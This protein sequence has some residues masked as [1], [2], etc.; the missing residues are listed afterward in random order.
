MRSYSENN[1]LKQPEKEK[2]ENFDLVGL[3]GGSSNNTTIDSTTDNKLTIFEQLH[4]NIRE[5]LSGHTWEIVN[6]EPLKFIIA[7]TEWNQIIHGSVINRT[8]IIYDDRGNNTGNYEQTPYLKLHNIIIGAI[9]TKIISHEDPLRPTERKFTI[10]FSTHTG[11][12][13]TA[14]PKPLEEII[15][16]LR[17][18]ALVYMSRGA[19]EAL[20]VIVSAFA[21]DKKMVINT[22]VETPG[23]YLINSDDVSINSRIVACKTNH[24]KPSEKEVRKCADLLDEL[25]TKYKHKET[26][27]TVIKWSIVAPFDYV[28]KQYNGSWIHWLHLYGNSGTGKTTLGDISCAIW[29]KYLEKNYK[30][31]YTSLDTAAKFGEVLSKSTYPII[32]NEVGALN[33]DRHRPLV[34]MFKNAIETQTARSKFVRKISYTEIPALSAC[35]L[36][37]NPQPPTDPGYRRRVIPIQFTRDDEHTEQ[38]TQLFEQIMSERAGSELYILGNFAANYILD[39]QQKIILDAKVLDWKLI[40]R[41]ILI[42]LYKTA[43]KSEPEWIDYFVQETQLVDIK[44]E[45][46]LNLRSFFMNIVNE[47]YNK[48]HRSIDN[49]SKTEEEAAE[50]PNLPFSYRLNFCLRH[51]L[52]PFLNPAIKETEIVITSDLMQELRRLRLDCCISSVAEVATMIPG[53]EYGQKKLG[54]R[55]VR[56]AYGHKLKFIEFLGLE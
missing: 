12:K 42:E 10:K 17:E 23:F 56:A 21:K 30:I 48:Y 35:I 9:P 44:E 8:N 5:V 32:V 39:N 51:R 50:V 11:K 31:P 22:E 33:D 4:P 49:T 18:K 29:G 2:E 46:D 26:F 27:A 16:E 25:A 36:T 1:D 13:F 40:A 6:Y 3:S 7:H 15:A 55:N 43:G 24:P 37:S 54:G 38:E 47:R 28:M 34:E 19:L 53:F 14:G 52:I 20:A 41:E 45:T